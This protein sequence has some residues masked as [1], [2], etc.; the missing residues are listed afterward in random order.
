MPD[1]ELL[2]FL[3]PLWLLGIPLACALVA[4]AALRQHVSRQWRGQI[5]DHLLPHL[6]VKPPRDGRPGPRSWLASLLSLGCLA[7]AGPSWQREPAPF[8]DD[9]GQ[10]VIV[11]DLAASM[12][13]IDVAPTR[14][15]R[16]RHKLGELLALRQ[17]ARTGLIVFA[18]SAH[19]VLPPTDDVALLQRFLP[20]LESH[21]MPSD[22][23]PASDRLAPAL[24][25]AQ[26]L[27]ARDAD[28]PGGTVLVVSDGTTLGTAIG[29]AIG[30]TLDS[31]TG[32]PAAGGVLWL[33]GADVPAPVAVDSTGASS[34]L[35][36]GAAA[37]RDDATLATMLDRRGMSRIDATVNADDVQAVHRRIEQQLTLA[38]EGSASRRWQD[39]G[40]WLSGPL[41]LLALLGF[42]R[43]WSIRW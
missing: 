14:L 3:R 4:L 1:L 5:A 15:A 21:L 6:V 31:A 20:T 40:V 12:N 37:A 10:L 7:L 19:V 27:L 18:D 33:F 16:A 2:H 41:V 36:A 35:R 39:G 38:A 42:R 28:N 9:R 30:T 32:L 26:A 43:G 8:A 11:L 29:T 34:G 17:N 24:A 22:G 13:A 25:K 23:T